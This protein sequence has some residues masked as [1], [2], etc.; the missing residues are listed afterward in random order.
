MKNFYPNIILLS[1]T[2]R[3]VGKTTFV[4]RFIKHFGQLEITTIKVSPHWHSS[5]QG[6]VLLYEE[7]RLLLA[8][9]TNRESPKDTSRML[10]CGA[11]DVYYLQHTDEE[12]LMRAFHFLMKDG[13]EKI[14]MIVETA[15]L[16]KYIRPALHF[17]I[18][19]IEME[20]PRKKLPDVPFDRLVTF[21]GEDF[22][23]HP[24]DISWDDGISGWRANGFPVKE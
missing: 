22:D 19:R 10:R 18:T 14:P 3:N 6:E 5:R 20:F 21:N 9:E 12:A 4:C 17:R 1:G 16:A 23:M 2:G 13:M 8:R 11:R 7:Q 24:D 15:L